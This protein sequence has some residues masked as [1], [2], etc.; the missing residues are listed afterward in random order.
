MSAF[1]P[2]LL[3]HRILEAALGRGAVADHIEEK[4]FTFT[5]SAHE[6]VVAP[7]DLTEPKGSE[8]NARLPETAPDRIRWE[9]VRPGR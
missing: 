8:V 4:R 7:S 2:R 5:R 3:N 1:S 9:R 6:Q